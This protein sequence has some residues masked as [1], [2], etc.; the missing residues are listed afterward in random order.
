MAIWVSTI[1]FHINCIACPPQ[2]QVIRMAKLN[3]KFHQ[4]KVILAITL[5]NSIRG[6]KVKCPIL[7]NMLQR[8]STKVLIL[9]SIKT[10][11]FRTFQ[12]ETPCNI[13]GCF[14]RKYSVR[15]HIR[16]K[17]QLKKSFSS[18][19]MTLLEISYCVSLRKNCV[20]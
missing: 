20:L 12:C 19:A 3:M 9:L 13:R 2:P 11:Y 5:L 8:K 7:L 4:N 15:I 6:S 10:I 1:N 16:I 14:L 18:I 17:M